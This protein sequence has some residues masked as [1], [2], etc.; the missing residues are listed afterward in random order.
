MISFK[1]NWGIL[2][3]N[4]K[5]PGHPSETASLIIGGQ[6]YVTVLPSLATSPF[7]SNWHLFNTFDIQMTLKDSKPISGYLSCIWKDS[8]FEVVNPYGN[9]P[10]LEQIRV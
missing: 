2:S 5:K 10:S 7:K 4:D 6:P 9:D 8:R 1:M 3:E